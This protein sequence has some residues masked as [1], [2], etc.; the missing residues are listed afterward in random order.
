MTA[1]P[2][3]PLGALIPFPR[4][5]DSRPD[6]DA[7]CQATVVP[8]P[9]RHASAPGR[10]AAPEHVPLAPVLDLAAHRSSRDEPT[11]DPAA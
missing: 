2:T 5:R 6:G 3:G 9:H 8:F 11:L 7:T 1:A 10:R 4:R